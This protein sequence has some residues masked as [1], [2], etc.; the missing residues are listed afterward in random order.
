MIDICEFG[1]I[2][3][4][5]RIGIRCFTPSDRKTKMISLRRHSVTEKQKWFSSAD[6]LWW[7]N[8][9]D[10][11]PL[12]L[13]DEKTKMIFGR[14]HSVIE[15]QKWFLAAD[16]L[17]RKN[18]NDFRPQTLCDGKTKMISGRR[19]SAMKKQKWFP[20]A[21]TQL[22]LKP[23]SGIRY[24]SEDGLLKR[25][26]LVFGLVAF[27]LPLFKGYEGGRTHDGFG[28]FTAILRLEG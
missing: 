24:I 4:S 18:K 10:F 15:K 5:A 27:L 9:N 1:L 19:H 11:R 21:G 2:E 14:R 28:W 12:A 25:G 20:T 26:R 23:N 17:W 8:K 7:K 3:S 13:C 22:V 6:T 16:T